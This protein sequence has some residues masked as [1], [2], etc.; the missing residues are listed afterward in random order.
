MTIAVIANC[1]ALDFIDASWWLQQG[2][3][4]IT[5]PGMG[6]ARDWLQQ[7]LLMIDASGIDEAR[8]WLQQRLLMIDL[9]EAVETIG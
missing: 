5:T 6:E 1:F 2:L 9:L 3:L 4:M 8:D 7:R